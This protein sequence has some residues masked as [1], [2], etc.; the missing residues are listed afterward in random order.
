MTSTTP[1]AADRTRRQALDTRSCRRAPITL[2]AA[3]EDR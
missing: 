2:S 1:Y 3:A